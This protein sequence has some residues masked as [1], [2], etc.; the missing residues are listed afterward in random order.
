MD[1]SEINENE[2]Y[3]LKGFY[4][5]MELIGPWGQLLQVLN[6]EIDSVMNS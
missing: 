1:L 6:K 4:N 5:M 3:T 2:R